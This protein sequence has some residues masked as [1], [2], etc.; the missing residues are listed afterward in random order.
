MEFRTWIITPRHAVCWMVLNL[1][2][3]DGPTTRINLDLRLSCHLVKV[4][5]FLFVLVQ[6]W[7]SASRTQQG[8]FLIPYF[9]ISLLFLTFTCII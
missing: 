8:I 4:R 9:W 1:Q 5:P 7:G 6:N 3:Q 2:K